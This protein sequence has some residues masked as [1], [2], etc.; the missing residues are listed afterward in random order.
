MVDITT[1]KGDRAMQN[2]IKTRYLSSDEDFSFNEA[3]YAWEYA[4]EGIDDCDGEEEREIY[5]S[6]S[7]KVASNQ[8]SSPVKDSSNRYQNSFTTG[9][10]FAARSVDQVNTNRRGFNRC[11]STQFATTNYDLDQESAANATGCLSGSSSRLFIPMNSASTEVNEVSG[12]ISP[13]LNQQSCFSTSHQSCRCKRAQMAYQ[14]GLREG[15]RKGYCACRQQC[16]CKNNS[17]WN[18]F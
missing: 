5:D 7:K 13:S 2:N 18:H 6:S 14:R 1:D 3:D 16:C 4:E 11:S 15:Y 12:E 9:H 17:S 10:V 8:S